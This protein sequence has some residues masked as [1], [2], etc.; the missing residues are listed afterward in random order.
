MLSKHDRKSRIRIT[1]GVTGAMTLTLAGLA[2]TASGTQAAANLR[3]DVGEAIGVDLQD[4][5]AAPDVPGAPDT[6]RE[7]DVPAAPP[8]PEAGKREKK[9]VQVVR[10]VTKDKDGKVTITEESDG[11]T[12]RIF[13]HRMVIKD[14][15][16]I[17]PPAPPGAPA[18]PNVPAV[19][20][21]KCGGGAS[22]DV[23]IERRDGDKRKIIICTDRIE[24]R[25]AAGAARAEAGAARADR[26]RVVAM[27]SADMGKRHALISLKMARR[28][29]EAQQNLTADQ[30]A[31]AL[32]GLDEAIRELESSDED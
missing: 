10:I 4:P 30:K 21:A 11:T 8:A 17:A 16:V 23:K 18:A 22:D 19:I 7:P 12:P 32:S 3:A 20:S 28:S 15:K 27:A 13:T 31:N 25:A 26:A 24:A 5:P 9:T 14:G 29:I 6:L 1:A 2:L